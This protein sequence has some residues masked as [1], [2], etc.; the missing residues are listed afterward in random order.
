[1]EYRLDG[2]TFSMSYEGLREEHVRICGMTDAEFMEALPAA[3]HLACVICFLK[4]RPTYL[5][6]SDCGVIHELVHLL[7]IPDGN[8]TPLPSIRMLFADALKLAP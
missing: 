8:T 4:E 7:H 6:L 5:C 3:L 1:M 2:R